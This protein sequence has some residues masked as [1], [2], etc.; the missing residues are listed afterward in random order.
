M[1]DI[2][3]FLYEEDKAKKDKPLKKGRGVD[4]DKYVELMARYK[5]MRHTDSRK[6]SK[7]L[8]EAQ[9]LRKSGDVS[10]KARDAAAYI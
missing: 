4:D 9:E 5:R 3:D 8:D 6:A 7:L 1:K 2:K 10:A